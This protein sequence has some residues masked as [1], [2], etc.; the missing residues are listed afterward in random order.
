MVE[1]QSCNNTECI[2]RNA[3]AICIMICQGLMYSYRQIVTEVGK[4]WVCKGKMH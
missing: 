4:F 2:C 1:A 3:E